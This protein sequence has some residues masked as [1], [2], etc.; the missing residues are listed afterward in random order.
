ME[1]LEL[2]N[3][4]TPNDS[5]NLQECSHFKELKRKL[6]SDPTVT[7]PGIYPRYMCPHENLHVNVYCTK[8]QKQYKCLSITNK[9]NGMSIPWNIIVS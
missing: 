6:P 4:N 3:Y 1:K 5:G 8:K 9:Q 7:F 2:S